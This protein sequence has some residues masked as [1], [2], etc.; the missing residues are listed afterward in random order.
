MG[1]KKELNPP[2]LPEPVNFPAWTVTLPSDQ[3]I[4]RRYMAFEYFEKTVND[5]E[6]YYGPAAGYEDT[7]EGQ[8]PEPVRQH[9][10]HQGGN[11]D[12]VLSSGDQ[13]DIPSGLERMGR[14]SQHQ[15]FLSCWR[16]GT[17]EIQKHWDYFGGDGTDTIAVETTI[18]QLYPNMTSDRPVSMGM[19]RYHDKDRD[20]GPNMPPE[21]YFFKDLDHSWENEFRMATTGGGNP[22][23]DV[24]EDVDDEERFP[25]PDYGG[26]RYASFDVDAVI[27]KVVVHPDAEDS[28]FEDVQ[29]VLSENGV[30]ADVQD[31]VLTRDTEYIPEQ[32][33]Y[34]NQSI[35]SSKAALEGRLEEELDRTDWDIYETFDWVQIIP[36]WADTEEKSLRGSHFE[37][38]RYKPGDDPP[39]PRAHGHSPLLQ[40]RQVARFV[41]GE[42][43]DTWIVTSEYPYPPARVQTESRPPSEVTT[44]DQL[45][46]W[47]EQRITDFEEESGSFDSREAAARLYAATSIQY[48]NGKGLVQC[49]STPCY[50]GGLW[51]FVCC[52][53][54]MRKSQPFHNH[55]REA[56]DGTLRPRQ[57]LFI[58]TCAGASVGDSPSWWDDGRERWVASVALVTR[59]FYGMDEYGEYLLDN[60]DES[61]WRHRM[62][63]GENPPSH[64]VEHGDCHALIE[65]GEVVG[66]GN[67]PSTQ[68][69]SHDH[70]TTASDAGCG[71]G[72]PAESDPLDHKDNDPERLKCIAEPGYWVAWKQP[73]LFDP[74]RTRRQYGGGELMR[75]FDGPD[76]AK[77]VLD[78]LEER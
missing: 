43:E 56:D 73:Q 10:R 27:N 65:D 71:C 2:G 31:S 46:D 9:E 21:T 8:V 39:H 76:E 36:P 19:V 6:H 5:G 57:P 67:P 74:T 29:Q 54:P 52:K 1:S 62:S 32:V 44:K 70:A 17:D 51:S 25:L 63:Q 50:F 14:D 30:S 47:M 75:A 48:Q 68:Y 42:H 16:M 49:G 58:V 11:D 61:V 45:R 59:A 24:R 12:V 64:A 33:V 7:E 18:G 38:Y 20:P 3:L 13:M 55:F 78:I 28:L 60:Y 22:I 35:R 37:I 41:E 53:W 77:T 34:G 72:T 26:E 66:V 4:V 23:I 69:F 15:Y 40:T